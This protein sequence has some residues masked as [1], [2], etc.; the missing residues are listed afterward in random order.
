MTPFELQLALQPSPTW[1]GE[2]ML[3]FDQVLA[4]PEEEPSQH[5][6]D[7]DEYDRPVFSLV[8]GKYRHAKRYGG[9]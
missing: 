5:S 6:H 2:Y 1:T 3:D 9:K 7:E 8:T 4:R